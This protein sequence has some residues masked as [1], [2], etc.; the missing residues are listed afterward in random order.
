MNFPYTGIPANPGYTFSNAG[1]THNY[2]FGERGGYRTPYLRRSDLNLGWD[3]PVSRLTL[4][5]RGTVTNLFNQHAVLTPN[6]AV[7]TRRN[8]AAT[9]LLAFNPF[10]DTP[11]ECPQGALPA[12]CTAMGANWQKADTFG[13]GLSKDAFQ[14]A[15]TYRF[16]VGLRF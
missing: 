11:V 13:Q 12:T 6:Q 5:A 8:G 7:L 3:V 2:Y 14:S 10:T 15:R 4:Y 16:A 1:T 9:G